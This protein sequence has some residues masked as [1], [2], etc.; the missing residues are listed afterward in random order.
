MSANKSP[1]L[2]ITNWM[3]SGVK[4]MTPELNDKGGKAINVINKR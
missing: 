4:Y 1:V 2:N 3:T